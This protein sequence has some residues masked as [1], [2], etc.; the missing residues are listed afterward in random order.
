MH[1]IAKGALAVRNGRI[2]W[3]G[4]AHAAPSEVW[5]SGI[6]RHD[7]G[8]AWITPGLIDCHTHLIFAG[9]RAEEYA[10]RLRGVSYAE[11]AARGGGIL[12]TVRS[13]R[14]ASEQQL[15]DAAAPRLAALLGEGVT[16]VE[17]K[18]GYGLTLRDEAKMLRAA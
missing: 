16:A 2:A 1:S 8:G 6:E 18:S 11:I 9:T 15:I 17:I 14:Q 13:T 10:E 4:E 12:T 3:L 5:G 7:L